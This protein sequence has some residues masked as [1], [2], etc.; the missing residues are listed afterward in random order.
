MLADMCMILVMSACRKDNEIFE[1]NM[2]FSFLML[3]DDLVNFE[4]I[5][6]IGIGKDFYFANKTLSRLKACFFKF[7]NGEEKK[8]LLEIWYLRS[9]MRVKE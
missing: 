8:N 1:Q 3:N 9:N 6:L 2:A 4:E 7:Q 5:S